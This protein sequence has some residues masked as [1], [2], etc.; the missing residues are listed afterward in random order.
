[1]IDDWIN[2]VYLQEATVNAIRQSVLAKPDIKYAVLDRFFKEEM[3]NQLIAHHQQ[4][5]FSEEQDRRAPQTGAW[6]PY[7]GSVVFAQEGVHFGSELFFDR[8]WQEYCCYLLNARLQSTRTEVKLRHHR[9]NADGFWVHTDSTIRNIVVIGYFNQNWLASDGGLLQL[10]RVDEASDPNALE[11][12]NPQGRLDF[13]A[14]CKRIRTRSPGGGFPDGGV[15]DLVL[16][17]Q[18][19]PTYNR[20]FLCD[21]GPNPAYHSVTPSGNRSRQGFVQWFSGESKRG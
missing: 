7:D 14:R 20:V 3:L 18:I 19:V 1:M 2:P 12:N 5:P 10:W 4:L 16:V 6:L 15:H 8:E 17:D 21:F 11:I 13:L 9:P